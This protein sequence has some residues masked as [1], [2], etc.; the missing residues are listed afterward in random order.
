MQ[1]DS[2]YTNQHLSEFEKLDENGAEPQH[3]LTRISKDVS[4]MVLFADLRRVGVVGSRSVL[5]SF[6][7]LHFP[8]NIDDHP[9]S[10]RTGN[11]HVVNPI[12]HLEFYGR[13]AA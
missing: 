1:R 7:R 13:R 8:K 3:P 9:F 11:V 6:C 12:A 5:C 4:R 10:V 2:E